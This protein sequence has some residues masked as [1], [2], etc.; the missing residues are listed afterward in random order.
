MRFIGLFIPKNLYDSIILIW[1]LCKLG[2]LL[3]T[4]TT[5]DGVRDITRTTG[6]VFHIQSLA[7]FTN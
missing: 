7:T 2:F 5:L 4:V 6:N 3:Q 1:Y